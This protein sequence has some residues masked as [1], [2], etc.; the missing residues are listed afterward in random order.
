MGSLT[1]S[2]MVLKTKILQSI[3]LRLNKLYVHYENLPM[4]ETEIFFQKK[5]VRISLDFFFYLFNIFAQKMQNILLLD[6]QCFLIYRLAK[7]VLTSTH[8][9]CFGS[10][11]RKLGIPLQTPVFSIKK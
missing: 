2:F 3:H 5:K 6:P 7:V 10:T 11:I 4:Q 1:D 9:V 8:N